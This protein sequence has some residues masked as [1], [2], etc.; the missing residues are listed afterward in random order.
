VDSGR[1]KGDKFGFN[2]GI[3]VRW[4][5]TRNIGAGA[6]ARFSRATIEL[7][8]AEGRTVAVDAGGTHVGVG[9]RVV[10]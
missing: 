5:F 1:K 8:A 7:N 6:L 9:L 3:D 10:F 4:M 2:A